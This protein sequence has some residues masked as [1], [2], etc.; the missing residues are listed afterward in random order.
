MYILSSALF[1]PCDPFFS[2][3]LA[4]FLKFRYYCNSNMLYSSKNYKR[5]FCALTAHMIVLISTLT[6]MGPEEIKLILNCNLTLTLH[7][8]YVINSG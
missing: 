4:T 7:S 3:Y 1:L 8:K 6:T 2:M 5:T